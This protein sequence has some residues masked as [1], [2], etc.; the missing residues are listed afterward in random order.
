MPENVAVAREYGR[1]VA[2]AVGP[3]EALL[4]KLA[5]AD[6]VKRIQEVLNIAETDNDLA[7]VAWGKQADERLRVY[8]VLVAIKALD[9]DILVEVLDEAMN[10]SEGTLYN[11]TLVPDAI[12]WI[13]EESGANIRE[14]IVELR[15][16]L[17]IKD[18]RLNVAEANVEVPLLTRA[19]DE[20]LNIAEGIVNL[21]IAVS[22][23]LLEII[24]EVVNVSE[25]R[26]TTLG[27]IVR[28]IN[29]V[30]Q[31]LQTLRVTLPTELLQIVGD[32]KI[33]SV[34]TGMFGMNKDTN[35]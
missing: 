9:F 34:I 18:N 2:E 19:I 31:S 21:T 12:L 20:G 17:R 23:E 22:I 35:R 4:N 33:S 11:L 5:T 26:F 8:E 14:T 27:K 15:G 10:M 1:L 25:T 24:A 13:I 29:E 3:A 16:R 28:I 7:D 30:L 6:I 32:F